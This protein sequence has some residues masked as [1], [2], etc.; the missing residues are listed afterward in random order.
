MVG[1]MAGWYQSGAVLARGT[2]TLERLQ[3]QN[4]GHRSN[5]GRASL[6]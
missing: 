2:L 1:P 4:E 5:P 3:T 6:G